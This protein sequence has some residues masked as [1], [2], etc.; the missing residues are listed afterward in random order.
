MH[1]QV[2]DNRTTATHSILVDPEDKELLN[3]S[4]WFIGVNGYVVRNCR[5]GD[6]KS[7]E[8]LHRLIMKCESG[9]YVDH[10]N[11]DR[12]DN[13]RSNLRKCS[14]QQNSWNSGLS[15]ANRSGYKGVSWHK[16]CS[17]WT[18]RIKANG[19]H[20]SLGLHVNKVEAAKAYDNA[21]KEYFGEFAR[22]NFPDGYP[23]DNPSIIRI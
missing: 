14:N 8:L 21:A 3:G 2:N 22:L 4:N 9:E 1:S 15:K 19:K 12:L 16:Q 18:V 7:Q 20:H 17:K 5:K 10:I 11:L 13:R 23:G 6:K